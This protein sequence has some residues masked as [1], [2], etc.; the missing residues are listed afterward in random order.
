MFNFKLSAFRLSV[1]VKRS[2]GVEA[3]CGFPYS[4][5]S[6]W[7]N[8]I[9]RL[10]YFWSNGTLFKDR[11]INVEGFLLYFRFKM[12]AYNF[13]I[14]TAGFV[15]FNTEHNKKWLIPISNANSLMKVYKTGE[16]WMWGRG[17]G[18]DGGMGQ[19]L[20]ALIIF[21]HLELYISCSLHVQSKR[22]NTVILNKN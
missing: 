4:K 19:R 8:I 17:V 10:N 11:S 12:M 1:S 14:V 18:G 13:K 7:Y 20:D 9:D 16:T 22:L 15:V 3:K 5:N 6:V 21:H 2:W